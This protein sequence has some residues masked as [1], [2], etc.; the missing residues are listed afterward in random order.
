MRAG[1]ERMGVPMR[2]IR[3]GLATHYH[4]DH[5]GLAEE[6]KLAAV[7]LLV[8]ESQV[9]TIPLMKEWTKPQDRCVD[10]RPDGNLVISFAESR[11]LLG[12]LGRGIACSQG[13]NHARSNQSWSSVVQ[14][15]LAS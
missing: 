2:E 15:A 3:Y 12:R 9:S 13:V 4:L 6:L 10:V 14:E 1:L 7:P 5:A 8:L 11:G